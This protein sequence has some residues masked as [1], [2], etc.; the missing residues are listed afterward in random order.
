MKE[1]HWP[2][3]ALALILCLVMVLGFFPSGIVSRA[4]AATTGYV[5]DNLVLFLD[6]LDNTGSGHSNTATTWTNLAK[7]DEQIAIPDG[8]A[9]K[10]VK[11]TW[12]D[13]Y[14]DLS[15]YIKLPASVHAAIA[16]G[17]YTIEF[18]IDDYSGVTNHTTN[19]VTQN[20]MALTGN[21]AWIAANTKNTPTAGTPNDEFVIYQNRPEWSGT[22]VHLKNTGDGSATRAN[23]AAT[24]IDNVTNA[25][26]FKAGSKSNWYQNG[27]VASTSGYTYTAAPS[28]GSSDTYQVIFGAAMDTVAGRCFQGKVKAIRI[29]DRVLSA[30]ELKT[31]ADKDAE[32]FAEKPATI[33]VPDGYVTDNLVFFVDAKLNT[34]TGYSATTTEWV[35]LTDAT[36]ATKV[37]TNGNTWG[38]DTEYKDSYYLNFNNNYVILPEEVRAAIDG[39]SEFTIEFLLDDMD[40]ALGT[41][42][43][44]VKN[45]IS[46]TGDDAWIKSMTDAGSKGG[47]VNDN[48]VIFM[49]GSSSGSN[50]D[51][52]CFRTCYGSGWSA[53]YSS[54]A[55]VAAGTVSGVTNT[56][57]FKSG[58]KSVWYQDG[59]QA[60]STTNKS[61]TVDLSGFKI[62][63]TWQTTRK[64]QVT[65]GAPT[66]VISGRTFKANVRA[67]RI[68]SD[69]LTAQEAAQNAA[70]DISRYYTDPEADHTHVWETDWT[71]TST[72]HYYAC[73]V[74][75]CEAKRSQGNHDYTNDD[76]A[77][78]N[79]CGYTR[80]VKSVV[81]SYD[82]DIYE[83]VTDV[84]TAPIIMQAATDATKDVSAETKRP[85]AVIFEVKVES[86]V[87]NAYD[88]ATKLGTW[89]DLYA[90]NC[91]KA[92]VGARISDMDTATALADWAKEERVGNLWVI[93]NDVEMIEIVTAKRA[94]VR[95]V[96]DF[97]GD[98]VRGPANIEFDFDT[99]GDG[100]VEDKVDASA[101]N[102]IIGGE[103]ANNAKRTYDWVT[104]TKG[105]KDTVY[106][107]MD[108]ADIYDLVF[109]EGYRSII[110]PESAATND[111]IYFL[112]GSL[113]YTIVETDAATEE[114]MYEMI[115][116]GPNGII[117]DD[118]AGF[119]DVLE[120]DIFDVDGKNIL[121]RGGSIVGHRGDMGY[122]VKGQKTLPENSVES[123]ISSAQSGASSV[124]FDMY[125]TLDGELVLNHNASIAGYFEYGPNT[126]DN[127]TRIA[128]SVGITSRYWYGDMEY[129]VST[130]NSDIPMQ[131][132]QDLYE[133][134]D[135]EFPELRLHHEIKD[136]RTEC[137]NRTI[138]LMDEYGLRD[139]SDMMCFTYSV[140]FYTA[141]MGISS[142]FLGTP[143]S[144]NTADRIYEAERTYRPIN[145]TWHTTW[146]NINTE[147]LEQLK[148]FGQ[149]AYPWS[150]YSGTNGGYY[151]LGYQGFTT[152]NPH[153]TDDYIRELVA[154]YNA[155]N[156]TVSAVASTLADHNMGTAPGKSDRVPD[157]YE[158]ITLPDY[159]QNYWVTKGVSDGKREYT[160]TDGL[161]IVV[162]EGAEN[163]SVNGNVITKKE[164]AASGTATIA[165]RYLQT[166]SGGSY[167]TYSRPIE[168][169]INEDIENFS[170]TANSAAKYDGTAKVSATVAVGTPADA[171]ITYKWIEGNQEKT[172]NTVPS[173]T[174]VGTYAVSYTVSK[175]GYNDVTGSY[176][177]EIEK[178]D[179]TDYEVE[180]ITGAVYNTAAQESATVAI[181]TGAA[182][183]YSTDGGN[184]WSSAL[185]E[186][187]DAN[188][189]TVQY[190]ITKANYNEVAGSYNFTIANAPASELNV[191]ADNINVV[192]DGTAKE[193]LVT[194]IAGATVEYSTDGGNTWDTVVPSFTDVV[195]TTVDYRVSKTNYDMATGEIAVKITN[196]AMTVTADD[197]EKV[198]DGTAAGVVVNAPESATVEY[199]LDEQNWTTVAPLFTD[200]V[201][202]TVYYRVT[203]ANY[204][205][206]NGEVTVK[207][208]NADMADIAVTPV[209]GAVY[210]GVAQPSASV[211]IPEGAAIEYSVDGENW[212]SELPKFT[213]AG[214]YEVQYKIAKAN[215]NDVAGNYEFS[216]AKATLTGYEVKAKEA[217]KYDGQAKASATVTLPE[218]AAIEYSVDGE[219]WSSEQPKFTAV[220]TYEVSYKITKA[221]YNDVTGKYEFTIEKG[222]LTGY[223]VKAS[224]EVKYDGEAKPSADVTLPEGAKIEYKWTEDGEEKTSA[225]APT[226]T[227]AATYEVEYTISKDGYND[228]KGSYEFTVEP[229]KLEGVKVEAAEKTE[230]TGKNQIAAV[231]EDLPEDADFYFALFDEDGK[232]LK[233]YAVNE[234][235]EFKEVGKY[236]LGVAIS[237]GSNYEPIVEYFTFEITEAA[238]ETGDTAALGLW[239]VMLILSAAG[240]VILSA[241]KKSKK[242]AR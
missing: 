130:Y 196:A 24:S 100:T 85:S 34:G 45:I 109:T 84:N 202:T 72:E 223:E 185:P 166:I 102:K 40:E 174:A 22:T 87:L 19:G 157:D 233:E 145:S 23:V 20:I 28:V 172:S 144:Y 158:V 113:V 239:M 234:V 13:K 211:T 67:I 26:T 228:V 107:N 139:R 55:K 70:M 21:D 222:E 136:N 43:S 182:I 156:G 17:E 127:I 231:I 131:R 126:P 187:T 190:K 208:T 229:A 206:V 237:K 221:N 225:T 150:T 121:V 66:D 181:P 179:L 167:Y 232:L 122:H 6:A 160:I 92:N 108:W 82:V 95:G 42:T 148:H 76:D 186:F 37:K 154:S 207:I 112:Q 78:C 129:L 48:F 235:P 213:D 135:T 30:N 153:H 120:G 101:P 152:D 124:E 71:Q 11:G 151:Q 4:E 195:D 8:T 188:T 15:G 91:K 168:I 147:Y 99:D 217:T 194:A 227:D 119:I 39:K 134:V 117:T 69:V 203:K 204:D 169:S 60:A 35:D 7:P 57:S 180:A 198:Y 220:G 176:E 138:K 123:I 199:S 197:V 173:F 27:T 77:S 103:M 177:F 90:A 64:P 212:S 238:P 218:G 214:D 1:Y 54:Y 5:T 164:G 65:F 53:I 51:G 63:G 36:G 175:D 161:E 201:D 111:H 18:L 25:L 50:K 16:S 114:E 93:S 137:L 141:S 2:R 62:G 192:Y 56:I 94:S 41:T 149:T 98:S 88:G 209:T 106:E 219:N 170:I 163:V 110:I 9:H 61:N 49:N 47:V 118:Y 133:A 143:S 193:A 38:T 3:K 236:N 105:E 184:T 89:S 46:V 210:N 31:N 165:V 104:Y 183:E 224:E 162:L 155:N 240:C 205:T 33:A 96:V 146:G 159:L 128:D 125:L 58:D 68:Y 216:I 75:G 171:T 142:Q 191:V 59:T 12:N 44:L 230:Y 80:L 81:A 116:A 52:F 10:D 140:V 83:P 226:F 29:Y 74:S 132:L 178:G 215:Y 200:V 86:G 14:L 32:R 242:S 73:T 241:N 115:V 79:T 189:Y 97:T